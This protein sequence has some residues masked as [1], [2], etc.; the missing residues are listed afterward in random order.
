MTAMANSNT[1]HNVR[2]NRASNMSTS[3]MGGDRTRPHTGMGQGFTGKSSTWNSAN[4]WADSRNESS[5]EVKTG[6]S[7][8]LSSS[9]TDWSGR[10]S[11]F[12]WTTASTNLA[13]A[14]NNAMTT[15][16]IQTRA[17]RGVV[18]LSETNDTSYYSLPR[19]SAIGTSAA[20][21]HKFLAAG[22][23]GLSPSGD[24][25]PFGGL[26]GFR[27]GDSRR[28]VNNTAFA[29]SP[30]GTQ[31]PKHTFSGT[32][33]NQTSD[34]M[35]PSVG[36]S[37]PDTVPQGLARS[38]FSHASHN[39][40]SFA[41]QRPVHSPYPS[42][43]SE[44]QGL[45]GRFGG[46]LDL[47]NGLSKLQVTDSAMPAQATGARPQF[48]AHHQS[49]DGSLARLRYA[50]PSD[51][52][53]YQAVPGYG[54][55]AI[56]ELQYA[57]QTNRSRIGDGPVSPTE[58]TRMD[59][60][61]YATLENATAAG[62]HYRNASGS[63][64][65]DNHPGMVDRRL[66]SIPTEQELA[67]ASVNPAA[68][69]PLSQYNMSRYSPAHINALTGYYP[70]AFGA[71]AFLPRGHR[72]QDT[73]GAR[74][75]LLEEFR[76]NNKGTKRY[77]LK[78]IYNHVVEFSGDQHGSRFIQQKLETANSDEK[79]QVFREIRGDCYQLMTDVFGNYVVQ[80]LFEH[81]NQTQKKVLANQMRGKILTLSLQMYGCRVVQK[82][83]E[84]ILTDQ[85]AAM[86]LELKGNVQKC[87]R[88]QNG[89]HVIQKAIER[90]P[91]EHI[92][93]IINDFLGQVEKLA[94]HPYGCRVVQRLLEHCT[95]DD[96]EAILAEL[97]E[98]TARLIPDQFGNYVI[99]HVIQNGQ[100]KDR[101]RMITVV[102]SN[103]LAFSK[104]KFASN[105]V[106]KSIEFGSPVQ[107]RQ[108]V[109]KLTSPN[110]DGQNPLEGLIRDQYGNYV[111][112]KTLG[113][114]RGPPRDAVVD[115]IRRIISGVK[116][117]N[118]PKQITA[119]EKLIDTPLPTS[120][121]A[122]VPPQTT[123]TTPPN[124]HKSSPQ[125]S[126]RSVNA[127][128]SGRVPVVGAAPPTPPPIDTQGNG[129]ES[130]TVAK[131]T[132]TPLAESE[133]ASTDPSGPV[134]VN[135]AT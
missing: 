27:N 63:R 77:E 121:G 92:R 74:S 69:F 72:D 70:N 73:A 106:E 75:Q 104:H 23:E 37:L 6:S 115:E 7:S 118:C 84:H 22:T 110:E 33:D 126:K 65:S 32:L 81:G 48:L 57:Y 83:L 30:V 86:V 2:P 34:E 5:T 132:V 31:F 17:E 1:V 128:E 95:E 113:Q 38:S 8:L 61:F 14:P 54:A 96:R 71:P 45:E 68:G 4:I 116:K 19:S 107:R 102:M 120:P 40:A 133:S 12:P 82:A 112:Q 131:S 108:I 85:Q 43:H 52:T 127:L 135:G 79:D 16:P 90:V 97:H 98:C 134:E 36:T 20:A 51:E 105:V 119:I 103:L 15:S 101:S 100:E 39:S 89:N 11:N 94:A 125:P 41:P 29:G 123:S 28:H 53:N 47:G 114:L 117:G 13:R 124:S 58:Y 111:I 93:F 67:Q 49:F 24:G 60:P 88:D 78:D 62:P 80:K 42:F 130:K 66:R 9:D 76:S 56:P 50:S 21:T 64:L 46:S 26:G 122:P 35:A 87:V 55:E 44:T 18:S 25:M 99:Q 109:S 3:S 91:S 10:P 59:S 129:D